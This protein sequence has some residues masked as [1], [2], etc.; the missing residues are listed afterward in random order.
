VYTSDDDDYGNTWKG[1][2]S[3]EGDKNARTLVALYE[4]HRVDMVFTGHVH[5]YE[6]SWPIRAGKVDREKGTIYLISGGG[7]GRL[8]NF[9]PVPTFFKAQCRSD[10]HFCYATVHGGKFSLRAF[11]Q[12]GMLF[13]TFDVDKRE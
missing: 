13:D 8:E 7:G 10:Y 11:D 6:R 3:G 4:K 9:A 12:Q 1:V 2:K 5:F